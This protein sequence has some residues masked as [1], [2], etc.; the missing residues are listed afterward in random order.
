MQVLNNNGRHCDPDFFVGRSNLFIL[1][2]FILLSS[3]TEGDFLN[4]NLT[5]PETKLCL[6]GYICP[7]STYVILSLSQSYSDFIAGNGRPATISGSDAT[8]ILFEDDISFDT[9]VPQSRII[10]PEISLVENYYV[11]RK[12]AEEG[13]TY[14]ITA[15]Y[16]EFDQV[17]AQTSLPVAVNIQTAAVEYRDIDS[18]NYH[19]VDISLFVQDLPVNNYYLLPKSLY[20]NNSYSKMIL[21]QHNPL[22]D[23]YKYYTDIQVGSTVFFSDKLVRNQIF[24]IKYFHI[25]REQNLTGSAIFSLYSISEDYYRYELSRHIKLNSQ[26]DANSN[27][28]TIYSNVEGGYGIFMGFSE[29]KYTVEFD[30]SI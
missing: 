30:G 27:P 4:Y 19:V 8:V 16:K 29:S 11:S 10:N 21:I 18:I 12:V 22:F 26:Y 3:C 17:V 13:K 7:D 14:R 23:N 5:E 24:S 28:V 6:S 1:L 15:S 9:L 25:R 20:I 2:I